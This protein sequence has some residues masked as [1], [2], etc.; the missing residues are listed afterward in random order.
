LEGD[1]TQR[2]QR[3]Q[4]G[5][6][7]AE[8]REQRN[9]GGRRGEG[10]RGNWVSRKER[11]GGIWDL[12]FRIA[13][14]GFGRGEEPRRARRA[15][16]GGEKEKPQMNADERGCGEEENRKRVS[17]KEPEGRKEGIWD[18]G[19]QSADLGEERNRGERRGKMARGELRVRLMAMKP[20]LW[21]GG[22]GMF[23]VQDYV[24]LSFPRLSRCGC[25]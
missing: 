8:L 25:L 20:R 16:R 11:Q 1:I 22:C 6:G 24:T 13:D 21:R 18:C 14:C 17:R 23:G 4:R 9:R 3:T 10:K 15:Q 5:E 19:L 2:A 7:I 12:G